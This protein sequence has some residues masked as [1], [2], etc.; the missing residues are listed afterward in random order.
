MRRR[1]VFSPRVALVTVVADESFANCLWRRLFSLI[2]AETSLES[3]S[4]A[5]S[6]VCRVR[7][8]VRLVGGNLDLHHVCVLGCIHLNGGWLWQATPLLGSADE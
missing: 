8:D 5:P 6:P 1:I 3:S 2:S 4:T 7:P